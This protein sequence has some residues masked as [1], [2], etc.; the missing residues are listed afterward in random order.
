MSAPHLLPALWGRFL[1]CALHSCLSSPPSHGTPCPGRGGVSPDLAPWGQETPAAWAGQ[2]AGPSPQGPGHLCSTSTGHERRA[3]WGCLLQEP[4]AL[5]A[6]CGALLGPPGA[7]G[8]FDTRAEQ[9]SGEA[10]WKKTGR[11]AAGTGWRCGRQAG[12]VSQGLS[13][14]L[15]AWFNCTEGS[16]SDRVQPGPLPSVRTC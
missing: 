3:G 13:W 4:R 8:W 5:R 15:G 14:A 1:A 11:R 6:S 2:G 7:P 16:L 9:E 12:A 10:S